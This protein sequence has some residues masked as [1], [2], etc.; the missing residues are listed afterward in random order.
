MFQLC[1]LFC[2][3]LSSNHF[4]SGG[5]LNIILCRDTFCAILNMIEGWT[6]EQS[7]FMCHSSFIYPPP[8]KKYTLLCLQ[9]LVKRDCIFWIIYWLL[10]TSFPEDLCKKLFCVKTDDGLFWKSACAGIV[11]PLPESPRC[12]RTK[13][14]W[15]GDQDQDQDQAYH[16]S[17]DHCQKYHHPLIIWKHIQISCPPWS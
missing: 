1:I 15:E 5:L 16:W 7:M 14:H 2:I 12:L 11:V 6:A 8:R 9:V 10:P 4:Q 3:D 13:P 17:T